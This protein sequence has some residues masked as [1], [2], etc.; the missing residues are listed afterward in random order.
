[1]VV[2]PRAEGPW[3]T[4]FGSLEVTPV[5]VG[6]ILYYRIPERLLA[7]YRTLHPPNVTLKALRRG[8]Q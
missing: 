2:D 6:G 1:V 3:S 8:C 7:Q 4:L 5:R